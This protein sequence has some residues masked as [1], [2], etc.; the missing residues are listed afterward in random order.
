MSK[1]PV[2]KKLKLQL[3]DAQ[4]KASFE[5]TYRSDEKEKRMI[6]EAKLEESQANQER[7][8]R[9]ISSN[10]QS[11]QEQIQWM[12]DLVESV[13]IPSPTYIALMKEKYK[14]RIEMTATE[15]WKNP[16]KS[17]SSRLPF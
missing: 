10:M 8:F 12:R 1:N 16:I 4:R 2:I 3:A 15:A 14:D 11:L 7:T 6:A 9:D 5:T 17:R 13:V